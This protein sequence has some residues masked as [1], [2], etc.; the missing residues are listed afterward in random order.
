MA[1]KEELLLVTHPRS[2][3]HWVMKNI[4]D[5]FA[6]PHTDYMKMFGGHK[7]DSELRVKRNKACIIHCSRGIEPVLTS[8]FRMRVR[9]GI[10]L[11]DFS[12]FIRTKYN[13]M[14]SLDKEGKCKIFYDDRMTI[15][16]TTSWIQSQP[17]TPPELWLLTNMFWLSYADLTITY[18]QMIENQDE[19][20]DRIGK[21]V[22]WK[23]KPAKQT[24]ETVGWHP[25]DNKPFGISSED[26]I[27]LDGF[28]QLLA[29][30]RKE[31]N[32][33]AV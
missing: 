28:E 15:E 8:V 16:S 26:K 29:N 3:T 22:T 19:V 32:R 20:L 13:R 25:P 14:P 21:L 33:N 17:L 11:D 23:R 12:K 10:K 31:C 9:N 2:G 18:E 6:T 30:F 5:N 1:A 27:F 7:F 4:L 24:T